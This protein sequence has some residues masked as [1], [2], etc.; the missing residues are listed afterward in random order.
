VNKNSIFPTF[1]NEVT[2]PLDLQ[3][4]Y[5][6]Q[7]NLSIQRQIG[8]SWLLT[9]NYV[10]NH[11]VHLTTSNALNY[12]RFLGTGPCTL[13]TVNAA[14][15][16]VS[17]PQ[18]V[19]S[20]V[21][22]QNLRRVLYLQNPLQGQYYAGLPT[23][24]DGGTASYEAL[25]F[26]AQKRLSQGFSVLTNY[27]W[28]HCIGDIFD[29]QTGAQGAS[30]AAIPGNREAYRGNCGTSDTRQ[31]FNLSVVAQTPAF[32][33]RILRLAVTGWQ[34]SPILRVTSAREFTV[35]SGVDAALSTMPGQ[36]PNLV[37][38]SPYP[39][40]Q[41]ISNWINASAFAVPTPGTYGNL[42][43][44]NLKGPGSLTLDMSLV[45]TFRVREKMS[46]QLRGEAFNLPNKANFNNPTSALNSGTFGQ[47]QG[48]TDPRIIQ[49]AAKF[50]F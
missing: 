28:S 46:L 15:Q 31:L 20:T 19:C 21:A 40:H 24:D 7:W 37:N 35:T 50:L 10:G 39:A 36:T 45:R 1:G 26:S 23:V 27:T 41:T 43:Y 25:Y 12:A 47:I 8:T 17:S 48:T 22:N 9:G 14:G 4:T 5:L 33:N 13:Q 49:L 30:V 38:T 32:S 42:G 34:V 2:H 11:T 3:P 44:N 16:I 29:T 6:Q 18:N